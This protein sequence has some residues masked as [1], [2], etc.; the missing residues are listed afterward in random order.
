[1]ISVK[2]VTNYGGKYDTKIVWIM[3]CVFPIDWY[4]DSWVVKQYCD[5]CMGTSAG[6]MPVNL[7]ATGKSTGIT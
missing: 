6:N 4:Q 7:R 5:A 3:T 2:I 1:M